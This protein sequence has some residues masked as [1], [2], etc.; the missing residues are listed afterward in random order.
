MD[1]DVVGVGVGESG[2]EAE[3]EAEWEAG[4]E[5]ALEGSASMM[6]S[7]RSSGSGEK[8]CSSLS[9][10]GTCGWMGWCGRSNSC[11]KGLLSQKLKFMCNKELRH[12]KN[13]VEI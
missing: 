3:W 2:A 8:R 7:S 11:L 4:M 6:V 5:A 9:T 13:T 12:S 10:E 1:V